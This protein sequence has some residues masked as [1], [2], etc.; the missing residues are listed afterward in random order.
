MNARLVGVKVLLVDG[1]TEEEERD[2]VKAGEAK[3]SNADREAE[4][5]DDELSTDGM[6][7]I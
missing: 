7:R 2:G 6:K 4:A 5:F 1:D 3:T